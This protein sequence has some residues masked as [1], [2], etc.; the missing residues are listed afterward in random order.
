M[1]IN[2]LEIKLTM[3]FLTLNQVKKDKGKHYNIVI[4]ELGL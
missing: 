4:K 3:K 1:K 2:F